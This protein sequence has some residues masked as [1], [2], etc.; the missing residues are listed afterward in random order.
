MFKMFVAFSQV[1]NFE[2]KG[3]GVVATR[4]FSRGDFVVEY[5]GEL[6][7]LSVAKEREQD[8]AKEEKGC[9]IYYFAFKDKNYW[10]WRLYFFCVDVY[11]IA[12]KCFV[13]LCEP[14]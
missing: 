8:Y 14:N 10:Y 5:S 7:E 13:Q 1:R 9:Y 11:I 4:Q 6:I 2:D 3:R 12:F